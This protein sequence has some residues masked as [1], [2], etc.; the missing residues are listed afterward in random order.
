[1]KETYNYPKTL[2]NY[3]DSLVKNKAAKNLSNSLT[4]SHKSISYS[5]HKPNRVV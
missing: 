5:T 1:M 4:K 3:D 2:R